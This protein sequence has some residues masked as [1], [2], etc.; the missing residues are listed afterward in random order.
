VRSQLLKVVVAVGII[1]LVVPAAA[2]ASVS[3]AK[4]QCSYVSVAEV[5]TALGA[6]VSKGPNPAG[7]ASCTYIPND[8]ALPAF[9]EVHVESGSGAKILY[10][11]SK[12]TY[13][14]K[15]EPAPGLGKKSFYAGGGIGT[16]YA[17]KGK[18]VVVVKYV[19]ANVDLATIKPAALKVAKLVYGRA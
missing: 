15:V 7:A 8:H 10:T 5:S 12:Q 1:T 6:P 9:V 17:L 2:G 11:V 18:S 4:N 16:V 19:N 3:A 14:S 13:G